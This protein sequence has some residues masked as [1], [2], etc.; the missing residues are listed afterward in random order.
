M[1][2]STTPAAPAGGLSPTARWVISGGLGAVLALAAGT[3]YQTVGAHD[4]EPAAHLTVLTPHNDNP[5]AHLVM[6]QKQVDKKF[7]K[8]L[9]KIDKRIEDAASKK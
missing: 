5:D 7:E 9:D 2:E 4:K 8:F 3:A 1:T 6:L